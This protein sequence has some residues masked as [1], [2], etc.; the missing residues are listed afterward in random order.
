M[1]QICDNTPIE[2]RTLDIENC[3]N[4]TNIP[5]IQ[6]ILLL[7]IQNCKNVTTIPIIQELQ[8]LIIKECPK[9]TTIPIIHGLQELTIQNC[10]GITTIPVI[11]ELQELV[12]G[13]CINITNISVQHFLRA[14]IIWDCDKLHDIT[15]YNKQ[16]IKYYLTIIKITKWY[17]RM[18]Y[19]RSKRM[20]NLWTIAE[21]YTSK[22]YAPIN[23]LRYIDLDD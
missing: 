23:A 16:E 13:H 15:S 1:C 5:I 3:Q 14:V 20:K 21:Y 10:S 12:I 11:H 19:L 17:K 6:D 22:K 7:K 8:T 9:V 4:V 2:W 18:K